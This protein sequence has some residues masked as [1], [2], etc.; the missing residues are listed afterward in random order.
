M[1]KTILRALF[2]SAICLCLVVPAFAEPVQ[3]TAESAAKS[4]LAAQQAGDW[5]KAASLMHPDALASMKRIFANVI[6]TDTSGEA[7]K[8]IFGVKN[9]AE[10]DQLAGTAVF[11]RLMAFI[12]Q[13]SPSMK[14]VMANTTSTILGQVAEGSDLV[15]IVYRTQIKLGS[16]ELNEVDLMSFKKTGNGWRALLTS[17]EEEMFNK[18][19]EGIAPDPKEQEKKRPPA[20]DKKPVRKP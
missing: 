3:E 1:K 14:T 6:K 17:D 20:S 15:H 10:F 18:F 4:Y 19:A 9:A 5:T 16:D 7:S 12:M 2:G 8:A 11:E 13:A